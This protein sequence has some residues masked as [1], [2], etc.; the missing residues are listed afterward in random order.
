[1]DVEGGVDGPGF[2]DTIPEDVSVAVAA[3]QHAVNLSTVSA[4]AS[5]DSGE[6]EITN[7]KSEENVSVVFCVPAGVNHL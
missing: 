3:S 1:M 2:L 7:K 6:H 5:S 4:V